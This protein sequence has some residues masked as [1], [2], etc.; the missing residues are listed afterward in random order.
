MHG[1]RIASEDTVRC[2]STAERCI[3]GA[4]RV[5]SRSGGKRTYS[6]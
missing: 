5:P 3:D 4:K 1:L 6:A 2:K